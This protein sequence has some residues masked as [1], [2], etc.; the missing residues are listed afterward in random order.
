MEVAAPTEL[1]FAAS[2]VLFALGPTV[3]AYGPLGD[4]DV[5]VVATVE[6]DPYVGDR[7][8]SDGNIHPETDNPGYFCIEGRSVYVPI[9][10]TLSTDAFMCTGPALAVAQGVARQS[11]WVGT[12]L[13][14]PS[15][16]EGAQ[17]LE[18]AAT[19][20]GCDPPWTFEFQQF[21]RWDLPWSEGL[22][23]FLF[24]VCADGGKAGTSFGD[25]ESQYE[26][27]EFPPDS[28]R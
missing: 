2:D 18:W 4:F 24:A 14:E 3:R 16:C 6:G 21:G 11:I 17:L 7:V 26:P 15:L 19:L 20:Q 25:I 8:R 1:G 10:W 27:G 22:S 9:R 23:G 28:V 13:D 5:D 12:S